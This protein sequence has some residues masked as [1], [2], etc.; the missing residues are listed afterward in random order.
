MN[1][2]EIT[3]R[4]RQNCPKCIDGWICEAHPFRAW[5]H[6]DCAGPGRPCDAPGCVQN[7]LDAEGN[8][9]RFGWLGQP[10]QQR[11]PSATLVRMLWRMQHRRVVAAGLYAHPGGTELRVYF[12]PESAGELLHSHVEQFNVSLLEEK[13]AALRAILYE[14]GWL[15]LSTDPDQPPT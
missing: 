5:P 1:P 9:G 14:R 6:D 4:R 7:R 3:R 10:A 12:E 11:A 15:E 13:A 8:D 2:T